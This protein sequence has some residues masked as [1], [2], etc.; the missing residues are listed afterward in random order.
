MAPPPEP[1]PYLSLPAELRAL[2]CDFY[3][4]R[5][6]PVPHE[7]IENPPIAI[8]DLWLTSKTIRNETPKAWA[9][10]IFIKR[11]TFA[12]PDLVSL[13]RFVKRTSS[14]TQGLAE[15]V[16]LNTI[17]HRYSPR[18]YGDNVDKV[19]LQKLSR[20][21]NLHD[22]TVDMAHFEM[23]ILDEV[24]L[25]RKTTWMQMPAAQ[26]EAHY[27]SFAQMIFDTLP[28]LPRGLML[29]VL[30]VVPTRRLRAW[31]TNRSV[32]RANIVHFTLV[33]RCKGMAGWSEE[34]VE[35]RAPQ[36][37]VTERKRFRLPTAAVGESSRPFG[38]QQDKWIRARMRQWRLRRS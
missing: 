34:S 21:Q 6:Q 37:S 11:N 4:Q 22:L 35:E 23:S 19:G 24:Y 10:E 33:Y 1:F 12:F 32:R 7:C 20:L 15:S 26:R 13:K 25:R 5:S 28:P 30:G 3:L 38:R 17:A 18:L 36:K 14:H 31:T 2:V 9:W 8:R 27:A 29:I 16:K